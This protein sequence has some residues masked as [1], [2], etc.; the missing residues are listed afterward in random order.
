M[1]IG[2][3]VLVHLG[4]GHAS[5]RGYV[6][7]VT[8]VHENGNVNVAG[9]KADGSPFALT[10]TGYF[11]DEKK[12]P[13]RGAYAYKYDSGLDIKPPPK[14]AKPLPVPKTPPAPLFENQSVT[15]SP[16]TANTPLLKETTTSAAT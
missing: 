2:S 13:L 5:D 4:P 11:E 3:Q 15:V 6:A 8:Y 9:F 1:N 7:W 16:A 10:P 12:Y 14:E